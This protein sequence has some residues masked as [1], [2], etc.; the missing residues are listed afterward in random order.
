M[1]MYPKLLFET[2][3]PSESNPIDII[4]DGFSDFGVQILEK[5]PE[6]FF[7]LI[8]NVVTEYDF[9]SHTSVI[10]VRLKKIFCWFLGLKG[11]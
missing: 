2:S 7:D 5:D 1:K 3:K 6:I 4:F 8:F 9:I 10:Q 11:P